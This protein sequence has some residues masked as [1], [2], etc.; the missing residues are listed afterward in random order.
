[1]IASIKL[2]KELI[3]GQNLI[4]TPNWVSNGYWALRRSLLKNEYILTNSESIFGVDSIEGEDS[5]IENILEN[6]FSSEKFFL[7]PARK[8]SWIILRRTSQKEKPEEY[9][10]FKLDGFCVGIFF[11]RLYVENLGLEVLWVPGKN[12]FPSVNA[13]NK[14]KVSI[15]LVPANVSETTIPWDQERSWVELRPLSIG[16]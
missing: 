14:E 2:T 4:I 11:N 8:T 1:M 16:D 13:K 6:I 12:K 9:Y 5:L 3:D 15:L 7:R 10:L